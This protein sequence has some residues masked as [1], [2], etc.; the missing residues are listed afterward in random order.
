MG[1]NDSSVSAQ[2]AMKR[3]HIYDTDILMVG[4]FLLWVAWK[5]KDWILER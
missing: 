3:R 4:V 1:H 5:F 2:E